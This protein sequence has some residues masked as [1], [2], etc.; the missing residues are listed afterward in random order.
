MLFAPCKIGIFLPE[1][2][3]KTRSNNVHTIRIE[4]LRGVASAA[5]APYCYVNLRARSPR[6]SLSSDAEVK[7]AESSRVKLRSVGVLCWRWIVL[8]SVKYC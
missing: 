1:K 7:A 4:G 3:T 2:P 8:R 5:N 6:D